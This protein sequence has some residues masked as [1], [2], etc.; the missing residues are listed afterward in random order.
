MKRAVAYTRSVIL[1][2][3]VLL[4][5]AVVVAVRRRE[6]A[7]GRGWL[8]FAAWLATGALFAFSLATG[9][10]IGL[11]I[12]PLVAAALLAVAWLSPHLREASGLVVG[13]AAFVIA[14]AVLL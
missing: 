7:G 5:G 4:I 12:L 6:Y 11:F 8:W 13:A 3:P 14:V 1:L 2:Y 9:F 10:S